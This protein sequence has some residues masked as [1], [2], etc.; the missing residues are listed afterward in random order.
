MTTGSSTGSGRRP[1]NV[2]DATQ[3]HFIGFGSGSAILEVEP[4]PTQ[5]QLFDD[6]GDELVAESMSH[7]VCG[8]KELT[9]APDRLPVGYDRGVVNGL[10]SLVAAV[11]ARVTSVEFAL[12]AAPTVV[13]DRRTKSAVQTARRRLEQEPIEITGRL[14]M[15]DFAPTNLRCRIDTIDGAV[16]CDF[17]ETLRAEVLASMDRL[18]TARGVA[19]YWPEEDRPRLL[20]IEELR[21]VAEAE[22]PLLDDLLRQ[23]GATPVASVT[24]LAGTPVDD[25]DD[26]LEAVRSARSVMPSTRLVDTNVV[27]FLWQGRPEAEFFRAAVEDA[28]L[29]L[30]FTTIGEVWYG[31]AKRNWGEHRHNALAAAIRPYAVLPISAPAACP[32]ALAPPEESLQERQLTA[33]RAPSRDLAP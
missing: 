5:A 17:D 2:V 32:R 19:E 27:S 29:A 11:G 10:T 8:I 20:H 1:A 9:D 23:Q 7:F 30:S 22:E 21:A 4:R 3:L 33:R 18:V 24:E 13:A 16:A 31:A 26:F 15:G 14:H 6:E 28:T 25:F 12:G